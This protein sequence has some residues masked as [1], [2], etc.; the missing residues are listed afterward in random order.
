MKVSMF[1]LA[2]GCLVN[3]ILDPIMIFGVGS[4]PALGI[5]GAALATGLGQTFSLIVYLIVYFSAR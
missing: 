1:A 5:T 4:S 2:G 3:I